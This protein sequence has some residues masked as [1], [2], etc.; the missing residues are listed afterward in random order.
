[1]STSQSF[2]IETEKRRFISASSAALKQAICVA[3]L[4][5]G[6]DSCQQ[7]RFV[8]ENQSNAGNDSM[9]WD[10]SDLLCLAGSTTFLS[11]GLEWVCQIF[12]AETNCLGMFF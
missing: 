12:L 2:R 9:N 5:C 7:S 1:M 4:G 8:P 6:S 3:E 10:R 11:H